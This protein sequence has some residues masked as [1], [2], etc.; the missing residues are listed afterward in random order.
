[1][2]A[3]VQSVLEQQSPAPRSRWSLA[4]RVLFRF[5]LCYFLLYSLPQSGAINII[6]AVPGAS[7]ITRPYVAM[8]HAIVSWVA[9]HAFQLSG[10]VTVYPPQNGSGDTTLD[11]IHVLCYVV[12]AV[13]AT[14][15]CSIL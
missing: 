2:A 12:L 3:G 14:V 15:V 13:L 11:Y 5:A 10:P 1:M 9:V 4:E 8:W 7:F 6:D